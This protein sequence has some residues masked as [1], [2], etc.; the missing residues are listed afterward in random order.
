MSEE[1]KGRANAFVVWRHLWALL[2]RRAL[3]AAVFNSFL[4][5]TCR[6][7]PGVTVSGS[8]VDNLCCISE[9]KQGLFCKAV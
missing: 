4:Q 7:L 2:P 8:T 1:Q 6:V 3:T 5:T 9:P